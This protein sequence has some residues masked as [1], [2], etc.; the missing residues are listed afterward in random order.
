[1]EDFE[2]EVDGTKL[3]SVKSAG[4][5]TFMRIH[6]GG[7]MVPYDQPAAGLEMLN[8]WIWGEWVEN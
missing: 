6:G 2:L 1:M 4:N 8:R 7:H 3:G 5:F